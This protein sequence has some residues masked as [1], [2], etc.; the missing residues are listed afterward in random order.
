[1]CCPSGLHAGAT[2]LGVCST[3]VQQ[4]TTVT[5]QEKIPPL[6][7]YN[8]LKGEVVLGHLVS[9]ETGDLINVPLRLS[10][11]RH[12]HIPF[13]GDTGYGK[14]AAVERMVYE[15]TLHWHLKTIVFGCGHSALQFIPAPPGL[16]LSLEALLF[17]LRND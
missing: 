16:R 4:S 7:F 15:I 8:E 14:S 1:M 12:F 9:P 17:M 5:V 11:A 3:S 10:R 6:V 2:L 13:C